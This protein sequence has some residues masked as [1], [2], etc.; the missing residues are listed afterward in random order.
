[1][2]WL[3]GR[4]KKAGELYRRLEQQGR[5]AGV[6]VGFRG[7]AVQALEINGELDRLLETLD[8]WQDVAGEIRLDM[9]KEAAIEHLL[10]TCRARI[11]RSDGDQR[12]RL[13]RLRRRLQDGARR[14]RH[15][16]LSEER[17]TEH[18]TALRSLRDP[19]AALAIVE[20]LAGR[21]RSQ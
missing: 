18:Q 21:R 20:E 10:L 2:H 7:W 17:L 16:S 5:D 8:E 3:I 11:A 1:M 15:I 12:A 6:D 9:Q 19:A 13:E 14:I 4:S